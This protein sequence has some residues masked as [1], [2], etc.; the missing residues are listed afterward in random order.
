MGPGRCHLA[1][2]PRIAVVVVAPLMSPMEPVESRQQH[3]SILT[4]AAA[5]GIRAS[6]IG[7]TDCGPGRNAQGHSAFRRAYLTLITRS[8]GSS[9]YSASISA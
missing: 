4:A 3:R 7:V 5:V 9:A 1:Y 2:D 8:E 6:G